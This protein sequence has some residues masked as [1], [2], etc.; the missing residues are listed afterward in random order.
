AVEIPVDRVDV[1]GSMERMTVPCAC[2]LRAPVIKEHDRHV[3]PTLPRRDSSRSKTIEIGIVEST[4]IEL[5]MS[6]GSLFRARPRPRHRA[7]RKRGIVCIPSVL[8]NPK[9]DEVVVMSL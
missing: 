2:I 1:V 9:P 3:E 5:R 6:I 4:Q 8:D 7:R